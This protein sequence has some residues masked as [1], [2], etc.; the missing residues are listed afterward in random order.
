MSGLETDLLLL[1]VLAGTAGMM[2]ALTLQLAA[3][4]LFTRLADQESRR[5][6]VEQ[7]R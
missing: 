4:C 5:A 2:V 7:R 3:I 1:A 6:D